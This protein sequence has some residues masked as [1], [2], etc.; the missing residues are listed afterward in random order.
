M[1]GLSLLVL[2]LSA[3]LVFVAGV[4]HL[5]MT[6]PLMHWFR[7]MTVPHADVA[8]AAMLLN[9]VVVGILLLPLGVALAAIGQPLSRAEPWAVAVGASSSL[10]LL[11]LPLVLMFTIRSAMLDAP[12]FVAAAIMLTLASIAAAAS[13]AYLWLSAPARPSCDGGP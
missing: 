5:L 12:A 6:G 13:V 4:L 3:V 1:R 2:R 9:H 8:Q 7:P 11:A 10:A